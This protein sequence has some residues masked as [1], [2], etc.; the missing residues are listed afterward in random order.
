MASK[1]LIIG[2]QFI[3]SNCVEF[4]TEL[5]PQ[6]NSKPILGGGRF[7]RFDKLPLSYKVYLYDSSGKFGKATKEQIINALANTVLPIEFNGCSFYISDAV[8]L[9]TVLKQEHPDWINE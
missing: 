8:S 7:F 2:D 6:G 3:A 4:H 5:V 1:Y 9:S